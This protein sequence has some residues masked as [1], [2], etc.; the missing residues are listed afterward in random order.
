MM[1]LPE[2]VSVLFTVSEPLLMSVSDWLVRVSELLPVV[3]DKQEKQLVQLWKEVN[4]H[5]KYVGN[6]NGFHI[7]MGYGDPMDAKDLDSFGRNVI[8]DSYLPN[9]ESILR[10]I[11]P[12]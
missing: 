8:E 2:R 1:S 7:V 4:D 9:P 12:T 3:G 10:L 5:V 6:T 11:Q